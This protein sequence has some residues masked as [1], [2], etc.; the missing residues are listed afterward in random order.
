M[1][2]LPDGDRAKGLDQLKHASENARYAKWEARYFLVQAYSGYE[3]QPSVALRYARDLVDEFPR[4][5]V[6]QRNLGRIY[7]KLGNW[8]SA[9]KTYEEIRAKCASN[10]IGYDKS[11]EREAAYYIGYDAMLRKDCGFAM[12]NFVRC[13]ELSRALDTERQS[14]FMVMA[15]LRMGMLHD[16]QDQRSY[17]VRQYEKV[18]RMNNF[19]NSHELAKRYKRKAY[20]L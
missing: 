16:I 10:I 9:A 14:G 7:V 20:S 19:S 11:M 13:D 3:N 2:F 17:A 18:L 12:N 5:P 4:N 15:N 6:F 1:L 8:I